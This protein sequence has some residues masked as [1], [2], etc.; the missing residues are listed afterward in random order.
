[1][2]AIAAP[3]V[4]VVGF[5]HLA[6]RLLVAGLRGP[7]IVRHFAHS[8]NDVKYVGFDVFAFAIPEFF[9]HFHVRVASNVV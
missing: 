3:F 6:K 8:H 9:V 2:L 5:Q 1:M 7:E 4:Q